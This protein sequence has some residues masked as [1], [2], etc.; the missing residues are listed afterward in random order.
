MRTGMIVAV[1]VACGVLGDGMLSARADS[2][3]QLTKRFGG[4]WAGSYEGQDSGKVTIVLSPDADGNHKG[5][6]S[7]SS[8]SGET[9][10]A[11]FKTLAL[12]GTRMAAKYDLASGEGAIE[13]EFDEESAS[14]TWTY[15][16]ASGTSSGGTWKV[17]REAKAGSHN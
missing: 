9:Y 6:L 4:R 13:G 14:G 12:E 16:D 2:V 1:M 10:D 8:S 17:I 3:D 7:A 11:I 15:N 5:T